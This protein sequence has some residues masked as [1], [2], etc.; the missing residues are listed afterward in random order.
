M[1]T[2][3]MKKI[4]NKILMICVVLIVLVPALHS[5]STL[6]T[7]KGG[8]YK[9]NLRVYIAEIDS[10]WR[11]ENR[12]PYHYAFIDYAFND[13]IE[14]SYLD[15]YE[16]SLTWQ[17][18]IDKGNLMVYA[19]MFNSEDHLSYADPPDGR[20]FDAYYVDAAAA[21]E[22]GESDSN[23]KNDEF[24]HTVF[25]E[26]GTATWCPSCPV[27]AYEV[28]NVYENTEY[29]FYFIEMVYD[30][31]TLAN[32]RCNE[33]NLK[34]LPTAFYDGGNKVVVGGGSGESYHEDLIKECGKRD[35]H[36]LNLTVS[37]EWVDDVVHIDIHITN[38][39]ELPNAAPDE[40]TITG[41]SEI[42]VNE[43]IG[44]EIQTTDPNDD[45]ISY[46]IDWGDGS[47]SGWIGP[48]PSG[49]KINESHS[50]SEQ[51]THNLKVKAKDLDGLE[52]EWVIHEV[53]VSKSKHCIT[54]TMDWLEHRLPLWL[55]E[56]LHI[57]L[58]CIVW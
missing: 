10:R 17:G 37:A 22:P 56:L 54:R 55:Q 4:Q 35:V 51:G 41:P 57:Y 3:N 5:I 11:M 9:G 39:E 43:V 8:K 30:V 2:N 6:N 36:D 34:Y 18:D 1:G 12:Q 58:S 7:T 53:T 45:E 52:T 27:M 26:I 13:D 33:F 20:P 47:D 42:Q 50:W 40:P 19:V 29:P 44:Y 49:E 32:T 46:F 28:L 14:I 21:C 24:T 25:C 16:D 38:N 15:T 48:Y 31:N 23:V